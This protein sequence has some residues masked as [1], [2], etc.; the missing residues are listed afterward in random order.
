MEII[1]ILGAVRYIYYSQ[2]L[3]PNSRS[4]INAASKEAK[5]KNPPNIFVQAAYCQQAYIDATQQLQ[6]PY[7]Y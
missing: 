4:E 5:F 1:A 2:F 7:N 3:I 6:H